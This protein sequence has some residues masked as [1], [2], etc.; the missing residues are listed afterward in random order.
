MLWSTGIF[1][2]FHRAC[3][4]TVRNSVDMS[5]HSRLHSAVLSLLLLVTGIA[6][7]QPLPRLAASTDDVTVSGISS[8]AYMAVQFQ[9][10][11]SRIVR[12]AGVVAGG[13][14]GCAQGSVRRAL[15]NCMVPS[16]DALPPTA[17]ETMQAVTRLAAAGRID[18]AGNLRDDRVWLL[19]G[20]ND[21]TVLPPV[22]DALDAF[23]RTTLPADAISFVKVPEAGHA[24]LSVADL[25]ANA[26]PTS[27]AP[28]INRCQDVDAAGKLLTH[29]LDPLQPP[30]AALA[31]EMIVFDQRP[32]VPGRAIDASLANEGYAF[33][34]ASCRSGGCKVH[35][36]FHGCLQNAGEIG[37]R[38]IDGAGYN[39]WAAS[40][41]IVVLYPQTLR[42][43]GLAWGSFR[44][45]LN[46][47]GCWDWWGYTGENYHTRDGV[48]MRA[49]RAMIETLGMAP[50]PL[51]STSSSTSGSTNR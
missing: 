10:A 28:F 18:P 6:T 24:M 39:E 4:A 25:Q 27:E 1:P 43:H 31:G 49:V 46:P 3:L 5:T 34:P 51:Q 12:G 33:V 23:Y 30:A 16:G 26:C 17:A 35:V 47:K 45:L 42:R 40:N 29:L 7:A 13:P 44:W 50:Q 22:M 15:G 21:R 11:Y 14:Y 19:A 8:G 37:R 2:Y 36:A 20:G 41:R 9:V 38:F 48:Q 32:F